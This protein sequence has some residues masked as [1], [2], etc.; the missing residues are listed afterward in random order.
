MLQL[1]VQMRLEL[2]LF[3]TALPFPPPPPNMLIHVIL[4]L[5]SI[6]F[7]HDFGKKRNEVCIDKVHLIFT[8]RLGYLDYN[9]KVVYCQ[10][11]Y[12]GRLRYKC[13]YTSIVLKRTAC[14]TKSPNLVL[15]KPTL[16]KIPLNVG[17]GQVAIITVFS[18]GL[19]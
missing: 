3:D 12:S 5:T 2:T 19:F 17:F 11:S 4:R 7:W 1:W 6:I 8:W 9:C 15:I 14:L 10:L 16:N 13:M 18:C